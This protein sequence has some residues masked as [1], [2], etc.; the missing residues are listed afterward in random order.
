MVVLHRLINF[1]AGRAANE[2]RGSQVDGLTKP[3]EEFDEVFQFSPGHGR[4][5]AT[6]ANTRVILCLGTLGKMV[7][8][9][10]GDGSRFDCEVSSSH[11]GAS[12]LGTAG[13]IAKA[14]HLLGTAFFITYDESNLA[15]NYVSIENT[16]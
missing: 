15:S 5:P 9:Y 10:V 3:L 2:K 11:D 8:D 7:E 16:F 13:A 4:V 1:D 14:H 6:R 12:R